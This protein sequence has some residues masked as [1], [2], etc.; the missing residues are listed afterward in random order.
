MAEK[1]N[2]T[3][4]GDAQKRGIE[5]QFAIR[6][7]MNKINHKVI[8][9]SGKGGVGKSTIAV[10]LAYGFQKL[11]YKA[12]LLDVDIHGPSVGKMA[13]IEGENIVGGADNLIKPV[14]K[15]G[16]KIITMANLLPPGDTPVIWRGPMKANAIDQFLSDVNW[17]ELDV[18]VIDSPPGTGDEPLSI[19]QRL[20]EMDGA[21]IV[22]TPQ[23]VALSDAKRTVNFAHMLKIPVIGVVENMS[24]FVCP[25]CGKRTDIFKSGGGE[26][27]ANTMKLAFLGKLPIEPAIMSASD[28]GAPYVLDKTDSETTRD[29]MGIVEA[30]AGKINIAE[31]ND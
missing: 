14:D 2:T 20:P 11:G 24:G 15:H 17:G 7:A 27:A 10:N 25:E 18:L 9:L 3:G 30:I 13:G 23:D 4:P 29:M 16:V 28:D 22:T 5:T 8:V 1:C 26:T 31:K 6:K 19:I 12:G 21:V